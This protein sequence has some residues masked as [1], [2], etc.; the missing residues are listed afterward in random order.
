MESEWDK[1]KAKANLLKHGV[2]FAD[3]AVALED[4]RALVRE[5]PDVVGEERYV[6]ISADPNFRVLVTVFTYREDRIRIFSSRPATR[7][8]RRRYEGS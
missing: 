1:A 5:D 4:D 8:E 3:A 2:D 6:A 7:S